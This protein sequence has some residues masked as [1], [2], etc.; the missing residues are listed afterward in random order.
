MPVSRYSTGNRFVAI[1]DVLTSNCGILDIS[2]LSMRSRA[3]IELHG[4]EHEPFLQPVVSIAGQNADLSSAKWEMERYWIPSFQVA[5]GGVTVS[6]RVF[7]PLAQRGFVWVLEVSSQADGPVEVEIGWKGLWKDTYHVVGVSK[8]VEGVRFGSV[9][10]WG[11]GVPFVEFRTGTPQYAVAFQPSEPMQITIESAGD[12]D[13]RITGPSQGDVAARGPN[14]LRYSFVLPMTLGPGERRTLVL[15]VGLGL[16]ETSAVA[17]AADIERHGWENLYSDLAG[18]LE[19]HKASVQDEQL[20][21]VLNLNAFY[22]YFFSQGMTLDSEELVLVTGRSSKYDA[23]ATYRDRDAMRWSLPAVLQITPGQARRM[24]EYAFTTQLRNVGI[25][26][27]FIDGVV[28][29]PGFQLDELCAP[30]RALYTYV[31]ATHDMSILFDRRVQTGVNR[32]R[33]L[34]NQSMHPSAM[35]FETL[36]EPSG[37][38]ATYPYVTYD[39]ALVWRALQDLAW[40]YELIHDLDRSEENAVLAKQVHKATMAHCVVNGPMGPMFAYSVDLHGNFEIKD[41]PFGSLK[42]LSW[43]EFCDA[44]SSIYQ[45]TV[46]WI[47]S[48]ENPYSFS[49]SSFGFPGCETASHP[50]VLSVANDL[51]TGR[52]EQAVDFIRRAEMDDGLACHTVD[53]NT[54][55]VA[56]GRAFATCAGYLAFALSTALGAA[57]APAELEPSARLYEPPPPEIRDSIESTRL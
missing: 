30:I 53:E 15:H 29:Q 39:N 12:A 34:L 22:N 18:W 52:V 25:Q 17:S 41:D 21:Y 19:A 32:V 51:L 16:E 9:S 5:Q 28:M 4:T 10:Q 20:D 1:P 35:L 56:G 23:S 13:R 37:N 26:S 57:S 24:I 7:A 6:S 3:S 31:R 11:G 45:N 8:P 43:Y 55:R 27:R 54:G 40:M 42:L 50:H 46:R 2:F 36:L 48:D 47:H 44:D 38:T 14:G 33:Q 49:R